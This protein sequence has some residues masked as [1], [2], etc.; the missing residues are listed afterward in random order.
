MGA[1]ILKDGTRIT[2]IERLGCGDEDMVCLWCSN[3][4]LYI[5]KSN[6]QYIEEV[7]T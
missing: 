6:I 3:H 5:P 1:V 4:N 2:F 7:H